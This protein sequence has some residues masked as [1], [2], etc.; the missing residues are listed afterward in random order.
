LNEA[1]LNVVYG[2]KGDVTKHGADGSL[3]KA[4]GYV[5][6]SERASGLTRKKSTS[7][8]TSGTTA[9]DTQTGTSGTVVNPAVKQAA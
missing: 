2:V 5:P 7:T 8:G 3:Y 4:M 6:R 9:T 1:I